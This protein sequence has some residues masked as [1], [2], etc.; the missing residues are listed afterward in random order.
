MV[1]RVQ[2]AI[3][4]LERRHEGVPLDER[5]PQNRDYTK[6]V[7]VIESLKKQLIA[8]EK[9]NKMLTELGV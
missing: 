3:D 6:L 9:L 5:V 1:E 4:K 7:L 8:L 2:K